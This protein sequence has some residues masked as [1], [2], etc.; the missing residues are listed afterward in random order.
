MDA[1]QWDLNQNR[2]LLQWFLH[3]LALSVRFLKKKTIIQ[4]APVEAEVVWLLELWSREYEII[5]IW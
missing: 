2:T 1:G 5:S 3:H 4:R